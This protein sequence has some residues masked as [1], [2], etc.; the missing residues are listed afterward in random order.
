MRHRE[1]NEVRQDFGHYAA[2]KPLPSS[3]LLLK[4][5]ITSAGCLYPI[6]ECGRRRSWSPSIHSMQANF[7]SSRVADVL[8]RY[9]SFLRLA[10]RL[11]ATALSRQQPVR[12]TERRTPLAEAHAA[13][14]A[15]VYCEPLSELS[16]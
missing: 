9:I 13:S 5:A 1:K 16:R 12:P 10:Q 7:A 4:S 2:R 6:D 11:S 3:I 8:L 14:W 15:L